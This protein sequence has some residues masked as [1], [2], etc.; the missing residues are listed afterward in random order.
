VRDAVLGEQLLDSGLFERGYLE[1][2]LSQ[3]ES[4]R[5]DNSAMLWEL[6]MFAA[7]QQQVLTA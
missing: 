7:F 3:H 1:R 4:G 2:L 6:L 5:R